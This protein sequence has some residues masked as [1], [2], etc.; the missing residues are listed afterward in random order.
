MKPA[1]AAVKSA[2]KATGVVGALS[3][4]AS[5]IA[6]GGVLAVALTGA[7]VAVV[8]TALVMAGCWILAS[9]ER[10]RRLAMLIQAVRNTSEPAD[11]MTSA[12]PRAAKPDGSESPE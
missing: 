10:A 6:A 9:S 5:A 1:A 12:R 11:A 8:V 4:A 7:V 3:A 2:A